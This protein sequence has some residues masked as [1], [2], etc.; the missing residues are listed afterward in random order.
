MVIF[1]TGLRRLRNFDF[2]IQPLASATAR[3]GPG[4]SASWRIFRLAGT[5]T[6]MVPVSSINPSAS[7]R[8][9]TAA[10]AAGAA[11]VPAATVRRSNERRPPLGR[12]EKKLRVATAVPSAVLTSEI[13]KGTGL[14]SASARRQ[15]S[16]AESAGLNI[17][18]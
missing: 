12:S 13:W 10:G 9:A 11:A 16:G 2:P 8:I 7:S 4:A 14:P 15:R 6:L 18:R 5:R 17:T 3:I 1:R